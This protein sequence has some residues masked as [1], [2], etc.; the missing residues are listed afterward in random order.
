MAS[1]EQFIHF[2]DEYIFYDEYIGNNNS[3]EINN[4]VDAMFMILNM[5]ELMENSVDPIHL[6]MQQ[7]AE[8][9]E[10]RRHD[11][12]LIDISSQRYDTT[13]KIWTECTICTQSYDVSEM[14][15]VLNCGHVYH[16]KCIMEWGH[17]NP[18]CPVCK[19]KIPV[20]NNIK[21][22]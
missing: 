22:D 10:L 3:M 5:Y 19:T 16:P 21:N 12:V 8:E 9:Y 11:D 1:N 7:S 6:V 4:T 2:N 14:V 17:Y 20:L 15:S 13:K 18:S